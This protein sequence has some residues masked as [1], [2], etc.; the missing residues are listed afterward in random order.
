VRVLPVGPRA[1]LVEVD[2]LQQVRRLYDEVSRRR[3]TGALDLVEVV[4]AARTVLLQFASNVG[5]LA[6]ELPGWTLPASTT[7]AGRLVTVPVRYDGPDL[8]EVARLAGM[9]IDD[10]VAAHSGAQLHV[11]FCGFSPGFAYL[12][13][14]PE[15]LHV[16]R[17][18]APRTA[19]PAKAV[20]IAGEFTGI[21]PRS[22]PGGWQLVGTALV[23]PWD[24][25][26]DPP[27]LLQPG[28]RVQ[29][30]VR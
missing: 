26:R 5:A 15:V 8:Q 4:P 23:D 7:P 24:G 17:R 9:T 20:G 2:D 3:A 12:T 27:V 21:Y 6:D 1:L 18:P 28:D 30:V 14:L 29:F 19:V 22:S 16:P 13:G 25:H 11:A 10:V